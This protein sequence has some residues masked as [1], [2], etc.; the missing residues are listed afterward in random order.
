LKGSEGGAPK[1]VGFGKVGEHGA[2]SL[3]SIKRFGALQNQPKTIIAKR[4][5]TSPDNVT[6]WLKRR[7]LTIRPNVT[8]KTTEPRKVRLNVTEP[9]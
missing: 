7:N 8:E 9:S 5:G 2:L 3:N 4:F 6:K 1:W